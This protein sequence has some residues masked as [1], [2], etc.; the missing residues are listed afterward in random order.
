M[1]D[2]LPPESKPIVSTSKVSGTPLITAPSQRLQTRAGRKGFD[3]A[4]QMVEHL[5]VLVRKGQSPDLILVSLQTDHFLKTAWLEMGFP[6]D[7]IP[8]DIA[9]VPLK[10]GDTKGNA[11]A[12][13]RNYI[14]W[15]KRKAR[16]EGVILYGEGIKKVIAKV[17]N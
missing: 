15:E 6:S 7:T 11:Y 2:E 13:L 16:K 17:P 10:V 1:A 12:F 3:M 5:R 9:G 14:P 4:R 8:G